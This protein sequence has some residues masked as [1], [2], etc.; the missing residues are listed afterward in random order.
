MEFGSE[1][2]RVTLYAYVS[3]PAKR[4]LWR[5]TLRGGLQNGSRCEMRRPCGRLNVQLS[6]LNIRSCP[7]LDFEQ[8]ESF[9][10]RKKPEVWRRALTKEAVR[11]RS[12]M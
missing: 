2:D 8:E 11:R 4:I 3:F 6:T 9:C 10:G 1:G 5:K 12:R 7:N